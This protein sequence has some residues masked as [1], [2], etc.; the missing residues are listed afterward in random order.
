MPTI[1]KNRVKYHHNYGPERPSRPHW[2]PVRA[3]G[4]PDDDSGPGFLEPPRPGG[5]GAGR[6]KKF[7]ILQYKYN[8]ALR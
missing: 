1:E 7:L 8:M 3:P 4:R 5:F 6:L 2:I